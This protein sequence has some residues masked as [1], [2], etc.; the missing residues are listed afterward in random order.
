MHD[1]DETTRIEMDN[2]SLNVQM[3]HGVDAL[4]GDAT[5]PVI[6]NQAEKS[7]LNEDVEKEL[8]PQKTEMQQNQGGDL[9]QPPT[10]PGDGS[11]QGGCNPKGT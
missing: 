3:L 7:A 8:N 5:A 4:Q 6:T 11:P 2:V 9:R 1:G 10:E